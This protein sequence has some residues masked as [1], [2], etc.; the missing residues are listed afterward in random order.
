MSVTQRFRINTP[1]VAIQEIEGEA[2]LINFDSGCYYSANASGA[3]LLE[4]IQHGDSPE[5]MAAQVA[6]R[7]ALPPEEASNAVAA[8]LGQARD[9]GLVVPAE[10]AEA[11]DPGSA[12]AIPTTAAPVFVAP[13]LE[14][15][16]DLQ[17]LLML[18]PIHDVD[19]AGWPMPAP[20]APAADPPP[21]R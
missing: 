10:G 21:E 12:A 7:W 18:D 2:I 17:D 3:L 1:I 13:R 15:F 16:E 9:E 5:A 19:Q 6:A 14:K 8:F 20:G 11:A 4:R